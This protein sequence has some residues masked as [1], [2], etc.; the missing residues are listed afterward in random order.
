MEQKMWVG[1]ILGRL[2]ILKKMSKF[3]GCFF[4]FSGAKKKSFETTLAP[5][6]KRCIKCLWYFLIYIYLFKFFSQ[7]KV[8][9]DCVLLYLRHL[10]VRLLCNDFVCMAVQSNILSFNRC[11]FSVWR[12]SVNYWQLKNDQMSP[13]LISLNYKYSTNGRKL[14]TVILSFWHCKN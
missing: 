11:K 4:L 7:T 14:A 8:V 6:L 13:K 2:A 5:A 12:I 3:W 9:Y 10:P 1:L